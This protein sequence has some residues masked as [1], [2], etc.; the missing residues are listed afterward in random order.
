MR[1]KTVLR[2]TLV[3]GDQQPLSLLSHPPDFGVVYTLAIRATDVKNV[4]SHSPQLRNRRQRNV[5]VDHDF[6][7]WQY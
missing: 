5:L 2:E 1:F 4:V 7:G 3:S 6:H